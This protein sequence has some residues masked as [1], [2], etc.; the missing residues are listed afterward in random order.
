MANMLINELP[1]FIQ[2]DGVALTA[3]INLSFIPTS[4]TFMKAIETNT[5]IDVST[6]VASVTFLG[7]VVSIT[8]HAPYNYLLML[9]LNLTPVLP[10]LSGSVQITNPWVV[11]DIAAEASLATLADTV[12]AGAVTVAGTLA[13]AVAPIAASGNAPVLVAVPQTSTQVLAAN[14]SR[15]GCNITNMSNATISL[16]FGSNAAQ[17]YYG[18]VL[19]PGGTFWMDLQDFTTAAINAIADSANGNLAIQ[20]WQ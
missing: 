18:T 4:A 1:Y 2:G 3:T 8:F 14:T 20:E 15:K 16:S 12:V 11:E 17:V 19:G 10:L 6:N 9:I 5:G 7:A 13:T